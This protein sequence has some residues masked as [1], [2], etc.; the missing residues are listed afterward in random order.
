M[1]YVLKIDSC[2]VLLTKCNFS[3]GVTAVDLMGHTAPVTVVLYLHIRHFLEIHA[4]IL[5]KCDIKV[6]LYH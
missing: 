1:K 4:L 3:V 5:Y 6:I 2:I